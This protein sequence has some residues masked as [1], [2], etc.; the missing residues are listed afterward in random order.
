[1][2]QI[3]TFEQ[4]S[5]GEIEAVQA[6]IRGNPEKYGTAG[7]VL[8]EDPSNSSNFA[9]LV[10]D[11]E[12][13]NVIL[14]ITQEHIHAPKG[15][16]ALCEMAAQ[17]NTSILNVLLD[18]GMDPNSRNERGVTPLAIAITRAQV[19]AVKLLLGRGANPNLVYFDAFASLQQAIEQYLLGQDQGVP[20]MISTYKEIIEALLAN[21]ADIA[22]AK[23]LSSQAGTRSVSKYLEGIA[24]TGSSLY[25]SGSETKSWWQFWR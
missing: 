1:M 23:R 13:Y 8:A 3:F 24:K 9:L 10:Y 22:Q 7:G 17:G 14:S 18:K 11:F 6:M 20:S 21:G 4:A 25:S 2:D 12:K 19:E 16:V 15:T 5:R